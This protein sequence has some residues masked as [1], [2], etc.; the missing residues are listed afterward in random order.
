MSDVTNE[1]C[2]VESNQIESTS[3]WFFCELPISS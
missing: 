1:Q 3:K 2:T